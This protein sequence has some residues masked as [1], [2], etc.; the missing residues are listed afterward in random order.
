MMNTKIAVFDV[1]TPNRHN[2]TICSVGMVFIENNLCN[3]DLYS[4]VN[5]EDDFDNINIGIHGISKADVVN[6]PTFPDVWE[7]I[8]QYFSM[9]LLV[10]HNVTFDLCCIKKLLKRYN[11]EVAPV[12]Y[13]DTLTLAKDFVEEAD[14][15]GLSVLCDRFNIRLDNHHNALDDSYATAQLFLKLIKDYNIDLEN[16]IKKYSF[17][18]TENVNNKRKISFSDDTKHLQ[19]LQGVLMGVTSDDELN[20]KEIFAIKKWVESHTN[21]RGNYPFDKIYIYFTRKGITG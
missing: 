9:C 14:G 4:L 17:D 5:P 12:Y 7:N 20:D 2:N 3:G 10:G 19:E 6:S 11:I 16:Y 15:Y 13:I 21:L 1:E 18:Y 8:K